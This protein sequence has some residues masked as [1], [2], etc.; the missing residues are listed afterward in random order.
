MKKATKKAV[1]LVDVQPVEQPIEQPV[2]KVLLDPIQDDSTPV[3]TGGGVVVEETGSN[4]TKYWVGAI[5]LL[6][7]VIAY[8]RR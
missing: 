2:D 1:E 4:N 6:F 5:V 8:F 3:A 7:L